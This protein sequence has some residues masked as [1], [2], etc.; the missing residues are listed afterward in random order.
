MQ[1]LKDISGEMEFYD[2]LNDSALAIQRV[3]R[4][5][6]SQKLSADSDAALAES[7]PPTSR[8]PVCEVPEA[9]APEPE[10]QHP[11]PEVQAPEPEVQAPEPDAEGPD[12]ETQLKPAQE[13]GPKLDLMG[14][15]AN[16][17]SDES[18]LSLTAAYTEFVDAVDVVDID[19]AWN[20]VLEKCKIKMATGGL[21]ILDGIYKNLRRDN[22]PDNL[23]RILKILQ[24]QIDLRISKK[25]SLEGHRAIVIGAG[26]IGLRCAVELAMCGA[27]VTLVEQRRSFTRANILKLWP[28]FVHD[29]RNL[30]AK[31]FFPQFCTGALMHIGTKRCACLQALYV[32][33]AIGV[34]ICL[35]YRFLL[36]VLTRLQQILLKDALLL[37]VDV[38]YGLEFMELLPPDATNTDWHVLLQPRKRGESFIDPPEL[39]ATTQETGSMLM[40]RGFDSVFL[41][42]GQKEPIV[43]NPGTKNERLHFPGPLRDNNIFEI[44]KV[45][46]SKA[47][48]LV[49]HF[50]N[51]GS[52][53]ELC[54][55]EQP[56]IAR[57]FNL[58]EF[59]S[60]KDSTMAEL[61]NVVYYRGETHYWVMT[62]T[63]ESLIKTGVF[64]RLGPSREEMLE[65]ATEALRDAI[66][67]CFGESETNQVI[68]DPNMLLE[69]IDALA[70]E[71]EPSELPVL[72]KVLRKLYIDAPRP[73][74][75]AFA[76]AQTGYSIQS[77]QRIYGAHGAE[78]QAKEVGH[79]HSHFHLC[80]CI[81]A[82]STC[83]HHV[84]CSDQ[85]D[86][87]D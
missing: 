5:K 11:K 9:Q 46:Y 8:E 65:A 67:F 74:A 38:Q 23:M 56:G 58:A 25:C 57:Q 71:I 51:S 40:A 31:I 77:R 48:G 82:R 18:E 84:K 7:V 3:W 54:M 76:K 41:G 73:A 43:T 20:K 39:L 87:I 15:D 59:N 6:M 37:G 47:L 81:L 12:P 63:E 10:A 80:P 70:A 44:K 16:I 83:L 49:T 78:M 72:N 75:H 66:K 60:L 13:L 45:Q 34:N 42:M 85:H 29:M 68:T 52:T 86:L 62:P 22:C 53:E 2:E 33:T 28:F 17:T 14:G 32:S 27:Q 4:E 26:P 30:G 79:I 35:S 1:L 50:R 24:K 36:F 61:E 19:R 69:K 55:D 21:T 64:T